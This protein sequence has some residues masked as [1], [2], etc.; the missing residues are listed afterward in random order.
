MSKTLEVPINEKALLTVEEA[1]ALTGLGMGKLREISSDD[2]CEF[3]LWNGARR[4]F[5]KDKLI[6]FLYNA[7]SI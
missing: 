3:V 4:M 1:A 5:K 7:Y 2:R 6:S